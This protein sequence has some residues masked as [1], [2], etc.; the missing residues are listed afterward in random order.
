MYMCTCALCIYPD[1]RVLDETKSFNIFIHI[2]VRCYLSLGRQS[3]T[4]FF[5]IKSLSYKQLQLQLSILYTEIEFYDLLSK[6]LLN[7]VLHDY[8]QDLIEL[9]N[10]PSGGDDYKNNSREGKLL[11]SRDAIKLHLK[12]H[13]RTTATTTTS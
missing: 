12:I 3:K 2:R 1:Y 8:L 5:F 10:R 6:T 7:E 9:E 4:T 11:N 13:Y